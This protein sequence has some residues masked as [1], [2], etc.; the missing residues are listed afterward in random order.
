MKIKKYLSYYLCIVLSSSLFAD[1]NSTVTTQESSPEHII[2]Q[3]ED[4]LQ[5][6]PHEI[7][8]IITKGGRGIFSNIVVDDFADIKGSMVVDG[9]SRVV[10][11]QTIGGNLILNGT[12]VMTNSGQSNVPTTINGDLIVTGNTS[13]GQNST[14]TGNQTVTGSQTVGGNQTVAGSQTV[15]NNQTVGNDQTVNG[16]QTVNGSQILNGN[17]TVSNVTI[18]NNLTLSAFDFGVLQTNHAGT[19]FSSNGSNGQII[20]GGGGA[21]AWANITSSGGTV[22]I[23]NGSNS[24]NLEATAASG[25]VATLAA[26][27]GSATPTAST[28]T[29][30]GGNNIHTTAGG[31]TLTVNVNGTTNHALQVGNVTGSLTSLPTGS[32]GQLLQ[33]VGAASDPTWTTSTYP[34]TN[35]QGDLI[36]GSSANVLTTLAKNTTATRYLANTGTSNN[37]NWDQV[38]LTS[39]VTGTLPVASGGT[40][41]ATFTAHGVLIGEGTSPITAT[42]AGLTGQLLQSN[43]ASSDPTFTSSPSVPGS[44]TAGTGITAT[45]GNIA[46]SAGNVTASG[47][48][49]AGTSMAAGTTV[50]AGTGLIATAGGVTATGTSTFTGNLNL[51]AQSELRL[52]DAAGG[53]YVGLNAPTTIPSSYTLSLPSTIP[54]AH[55]IMQ[56]NSVAPTS[57]EWVT[58]GNAQVPTASRT[59]FVTKYG[60]D[61][62]G[63]GSLTFPYLTLSKAITTANSISS[64]ANPVSILIASGVYVEDNSAGPLSITAGGVSIVG[65]STTAVIIQPSTLANNLIST[66]TAVRFIELGFVSGGVSTAAALSFSGT[67]NTSSTTSVR[68]VNF[69]TGI[70]C[71]GTN[72]I[73]IFFN[74]AFSGNGTAISINNAT[75]SCTGLLIQGSATTTPANT[76]ISATGSACNVAFASGVFQ[77]CTT[78]VTLTSNATFTCRGS[79]F[80]NNTNAF[81]QASSS[82][83]QLAACTFQLNRTS[84]ISVQSTGTGTATEILACYFDGKD[85]GGTPQGTAIVVN[86]G[87][88]VTMD[89][90]QIENFITGVKVG[91]PGDTSTTM[92]RA[93]S[94]EIFNSTTNDIV[95]QGAASL[96]FDAGTLTATTLSINDT[97]NI[98]AAF[99]DLG[100]RSALSIGNW[101]DTDTTLVQA[102]ITSSN[103]PSIKYKSSLYSTQAIGY[104]NNTTNA[105]LFALAPNATNVT[106]ITTDRTKTAGVRLVSDTASPVGGTTAL[107]GWDINKNASTAELAFKYQNSDS[108]G[109]SPV[110]QYTVMQLDGVNN[111]V[112]LPT[113]ATQLVFATDTNLYRSAANTLKTDDNFIVGTLTANRAVA[114]DGSTQL[115]SSATT[116]TELGFLSGVTSSVQTQ[117]DSKVAKAGDTMT[118]ALQLPA[119][120]AAAPSLRFTGSTTTG[121]SAQTVN[122]LSLDTS[123][124]ERMT[125]SSSGTVAILDT[126]NGFGTPGVVHNDASGNLSS[127]L[128]VNADVDPAAAIVDTKL[129]TISTAGKVA[130]SATTAT[131]ANTANTIVARDSSGNFSAG[132]ITASLTGSASNNVLKAGDTMTGALQLPAGT[133]ALPSLKFTGSTTTGLS[134]AT[135][136]TLSLD[137][138][139]AERMSISPAGLVTI[140][141]L[142]SAGVVHTDGTGALSTSQVVNADIANATITNA[143]LA[144]ISSTDT[145]NFI[146]V[147]D[148]SGNFATNMITLDGTTTNPTDAATKAYVDSVAGLGLSAKTPAVVV[149]IT[150]VA[151]SGLQTIDGVTL[152]DGNRVLLVGQTS[153]VQNGLWVAHAGA[154]TRPTD[155]ASGTQ[156]GAAYVLITSGTVN[157]GSSWLCNTPTAII[158][159]DPITFVEFS[160]PNQTTGANVG[161]GAGQIFRDKTG[162]TLNFKTLA[163]GTHMVVTNNANDVTLST[164]A[165][166][167][168]TASTIVARDASGNFSASTITASLTGSASN[169]VLKAGDTM[170][171]TLNMATQNEVRFQDAA[172]GEYVGINAPTTIP[173]S[174]TLSLP[175]TIPTAH[176]IMQANAS[177]PTNLEWFTPT[178][179]QPPATSRIIYVTKYGN[180]TTGDGS[181]NLPYAS[182]SKAISTANSISSSASPVT[183]QLNPG[184][185]IEN[186]I[187]SPLIIT[188]NGISIVGDSSEAVTIIPLSGTNNLIN[189]NQTIQV[190]NITFSALGLTTT[191]N[192]ASGFSL[193][194][195]ALTTFNNVRLIGFNIG[196]QCQG[197]SSDDYVFNN[198]VFVANG[199]GISVD[200]T[201][202]ACNNCIIQGAGLG[203]TPGNTGLSLTGTGANAVLTGGVFVLCQTACNI[204]NNA[205]LT[206][207]S[208]T[209]KIN[210]FDIVQTTGSS[211]LLTGCSFALTATSSDVDL[212]ITGTGTNAEIVGCEFNGFSTLG[213]PQ[214]TGILVADSAS[215]NISACGMKNYTVGV[216]I[217]ASGT[218]TDTSSTSLIASAFIITNCT[219]DLLQQGSSTLSFI[220]GSTSGSKISINDPTNVTLAYFDQEDNNALNIGKHSNIATSLIHAAVGAADDPQLNYQP[221]LYST[222][223]IGYENPT[224]N[225]SPA[226][227]F[228]LASNGQNANL[229]AITTDRTKTAGV[230]LVSDTASP[231]GGTTALRGWDINKN[232]SAAELAFK[233]QNSDAS[234]QSVIPQYTVMQ[235]DGVNNKLQLPTVGAQIVFSGDTDLYRSAAAVLKTDGNLIIGGLTASRAVAT[236]GSSQLVSSATTATELGFLSGV[237]SSVQTQLNNKLN[238]SGGTLTGNLTLPAGSAASPS[239][240]FTGST[241]T[242]LSAATANQLSLDTN[243]TERMTISSA[244]TVSI[245]DSANGFT[246]AGVVHNNASGNLT[247]SLIVNADV[248]ASA[249]IADTKL[250]TISTAGKVANSATTATSANTANAIVSRD[251]SGNFSAGT[252]TANLTGS[253]SNN[254]LKS[255]DTMTGTLQLPAGTTAAPSLVFTGSTTSGLSAAAANTLSLSTNALER[256]NISSTGAVTINT[257]TSGTGL[258]ISGGGAAITGN[259][260]INGG[261]VDIGT[262]NAANTINIGLGTTARAINIGNSA[263]AHTVAIGSTTG[264][265]SLTQRVG[266][267]NYSLDGVAG[268]TYT[269]GAST[270]TGT[271]TIGGT[272]QTGTM[273][274]GSSSGTNTLNI[275]NGAGATT[276]NLANAQAAGSVN[277]GTG[278]TTGTISIGGTAQT[279]TITLGSSSGLNTLAIANGTGSTTLNLANTQT[280]GAVSIGAGMTTGTISIGGTGAQT[281][282]VS[283]APG[284]GAQTVNIASGDT[285]AKTIHIGDGAAANIITLGTTNGAASLAERVGTGNFTLDGVAGSTYT[286]GASTTTGTITIGG[287][288]QT[289]AMTFGSSSGTNS[290]NV[291]TGAGATTVNVAT[292]ASAS[293]VV[294]LGNATT[295]SVVNTVSSLIM[296]GIHAD[297]A[298]QSVI[299]TNNGSVT[300]AAGTSIVLLNP[301]AN[302]NPFNVTF[303]P[304]PTNGQYF[305]ILLGTPHNVT[306]TNTAGTGGAAFVNAGTALTAGAASLT[307]FAYY[308]I[309]ASNSWCRFG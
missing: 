111:Q 282:T 164:D 51:A 234:G 294:N 165:T 176:Q 14:V 187:G 308:Y 135:A 88:V 141:G 37:P 107:R 53:E 158:D 295:G 281:G 221:A 195:G 26:D 139:G 255:G 151:L 220:S 279:G 110:A 127:T 28:I 274:L 108:S 200:S 290:V 242:G 163:A 49:S 173:S 44:I 36:F 105:S 190:A 287:T 264:A 251:S 227:L 23:T 25:F 143:K 198:C 186:N 211:M 72:G 149:S 171:G 253:A 132:T 283:L 2:V 152:V 175:S 126:A 100:T 103:E 66:T 16:N 180:D 291:G 240:N 236:D 261:T 75:V 273:T 184:V 5:E 306:L 225:V 55:Q 116:A 7:E 170:T 18:S 286:V 91:L 297:Q 73:Y 272:A 129:A 43:G 289:G 241:T 271:I 304:S 210:I 69:A 128:I 185:Y 40:G 118:G 260:S 212:H 39:G 269:V 87:A 168:N 82:I 145:A 169:N 41:A 11:N 161:A 298:I 179:A 189:A 223:A 232:A 34:S 159:T 21:P 84:G 57:L 63:D 246:V 131:S 68:F 60:N 215:V 124:I 106:A 48:V 285:G 268:S 77:N 98:T 213:V 259:S 150:N 13:T 293:N 113:A 32:N 138:N 24:I 64:A 278:M 56:A 117:I 93:I 229:T 204:A 85:S 205:I 22:T 233:Y 270:T 256:I 112:Q 257:P 102:A 136:N 292:G 133:A 237:T 78:G 305:A 197:T 167:A 266:T 218:A 222:Q 238:T 50:T 156:A 303:P 35:A 79:G 120:S 17:Q 245:L 154:W 302:V 182:L 188:A 299:P 203:G 194:T 250:A 109:Q 47:L 177:T 89:G 284:T 71:A 193:T 216:Q 122:T 12:I 207:S 86:T 101:S 202:I 265:A 249:A 8:D 280:A 254:V 30:A 92:L 9:N 301:A 235:L 27:T 307:S 208:I 142:N 83:G 67:G 247:S 162:N 288:A 20:I 80:K 296:K 267:G 244:G 123:G 147:R 275:A 58:P 46:A 90:G 228:A 140:T 157:A 148:G 130:N 61:T 96:T 81:V 201:L 160:L 248:S 62:T 76:G 119:G 263:A 276:L 153:A 155:F 277:V 3:Q 300:A 121:L 95:Q 33:S 10:G 178:G 239:L 224:P 70:S 104:Q 19:V 1:D 226:T 206:A 42:S 181:F 6:I 99:F 217:G 134:A 45:T 219:T 192:T 15:A 38:S 54:T 59:I 209:Y 146:V 252:I 196:A 65:D 199:T 29:I 94:L 262:D 258:T 309:S 172:G 115:V 183:I 114:T 231:V 191:P 214:G 52:Q 166:N 137:T 230:R 97:T 243:G 31:S 74:C 144:A 4:V 125:I 174:Y